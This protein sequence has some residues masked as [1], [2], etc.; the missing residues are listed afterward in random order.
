M[1]Q[2]PD[3][4]VVIIRQGL[5]PI[6]G[7]H[8]FADILH[9]TWDWQQF[10]EDLGFNASGIAASYHHPIVCFSKRFLQYRDLPKLHLP[11][12]ELEVPDLYK[13]TIRHPR[14]VVMVCKQFWAS[15]RLAQP[16]LLWLSLIHI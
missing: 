16:P 6:R 9:G 7:R 12:W 2:S 11:G 8:V 4:F 3:D 14:D 1:L 13:D 5:K 15:D 10:F